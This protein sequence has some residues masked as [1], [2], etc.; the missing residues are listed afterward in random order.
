MCG[1]K[2]C[3]DA[4]LNDGLDCL[5]CLIVS[6]LPGS[7]DLCRAAVLRHDQEIDLGMFPMDSGMW[8]RARASTE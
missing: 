8:G 6:T 4:G 3:R 7:F 1:H 5:Y 2:K